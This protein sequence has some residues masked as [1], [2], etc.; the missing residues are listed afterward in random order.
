MSLIIYIPNYFIAQVLQYFELSTS[1]DERVNEFS[2][3]DKLPRILLYSHWARFV[4]TSG[5]QPP[6]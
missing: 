2:D 5:M 1:H 4:D 6:S 3:Y